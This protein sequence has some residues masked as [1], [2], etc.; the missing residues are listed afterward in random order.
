MTTPE[1]RPM[2]G[3]ALKVIYL[4]QITLLLTIIKSMDGLPVLELMFFRLFLATVL[5]ALVLGVQGKLRD[6]LHT[7]RPMAHLTR[8]VLA[9]SNMGFTFLAVRYLPLPEAI[10]LQYTQP[11]FVVA[12]SAMFLRT[13]VGMFR[14]A[15]V[16]VGFVGVLIITWPKLSLLGGG[17]SALTHDDIIGVASALAA[18]TTVALTLLWVAELV[19]TEKSTTV[20][21]WMGIYGSGMLLVTAPFGWGWPSMWQ[22]GL[23]WVTGVLGAGAQLTLTEC[24]RAAPA[25]VSAPFEYSSLIFAGVLGYVVFDEI[26]NGNTLAGSALLIVA[27][28]VILWREQRLAATKAMNVAT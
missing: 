25:A 8:S 7:Q 28:L 2:R 18:A 10:T 16:V 13:P 21:I 17:V 19:R 9:M 26:P 24:L 23:L 20:A 4:L 1:P 3:I 12:L 27:G 5:I 6:A 14:W 22:F 15:A 11:L